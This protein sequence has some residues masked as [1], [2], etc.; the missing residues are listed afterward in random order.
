[1]TAAA[2]FELKLLRDLRVENARLRAR[3]ETLERENRGLANGKAEASKLA[4][5]WRLKAGR[6]NGGGE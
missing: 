4:K 2:V 3:V 5:Y 6:A 1:M